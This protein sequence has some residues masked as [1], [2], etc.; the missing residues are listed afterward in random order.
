M[1]TPSY[2][3]PPPRPSPP[4]QP[5]EALR[6]YAGEAQTNRES[7][8]RAK[9]RKLDDGSYE[10]E[11]KAI[12][13]GWKGQVVPGQLKLEIITCDGGEYSDP[14]IPAKS[15][16]Q[17]VL[18]DDGNV[19]C[20]KSNKCNMLLKH[21]SGMPFTLTKLVVKAPR[22]GYDAPIQEGMIFV[23]LDDQDLMEK[24][25]RYE[26]YYS[27]K[28]YRF[29]RQRF[30]A[31]RPSHEYLS[32]ARSP[33][34]SID[35]SRYLRDPREPPPAWHRYVEHDPALY[36]EI[37]PGFSVTTGDP[38]DDEGAPIEGPSSPRPWHETDPEYSFR[39][40]ADRYRP[41]Y[42]DSERP[43][44]YEY[45]APTSDSEDGEA[46]MLDNILRAGGRPPRED[47]P[48]PGAVTDEAEPSPDFGRYVNR[49]STP[50]RIGLRSYTG[51][52][53]VAPV[54][55][56]PPGYERLGLDPEASTFKTAGDGNAATSSA[57][58][59][60]TLAPHARFF[61]P[62]NKSSVAVKFDPPV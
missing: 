11:S 52:P 34:R 20:T 18:Q 19:Y 47:S 1:P 56:N 30:E 14:H 9:R 32:S 22:S 59:S 21:S 25:A 43:V 36:E 41:V 54:P 60:D 39:S 46:A 58:S 5:S 17:N 10:D 61:I 37:V 38:S 3:T 40:Y 8:Y 51:P 28:S 31:T 49:R 33:L 50:S 48:D 24:T 42:A 45:S 44:G 13:Y 35:R 6:E 62:I 57:V 29:H 16:P 27:P 55:P 7:R 4:L 53:L 26:I 2:S 12:T 15:F 23:A